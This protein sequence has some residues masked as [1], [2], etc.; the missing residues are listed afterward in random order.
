MYFLCKQ[1]TNV[2]IFSIKVVCMLIKE[3]GLEREMWLLDSDNRI[4]EAPMYNFPADEMG[5]LVEVRSAWGSNP[6]RVVDTLG[7]AESNEREKARVLGLKILLSPEM[8]VTDEWQ[9]Y[10]AEK[11]HHASFGDSTQNIYGKTE[12][13]HNTG[14]LPG[15][16]TAGM[17][18]HF[19]IW[20]TEKEK[21]RDFTKD[22]IRH[23][24]FELDNTFKDYV[25]S[26][27]RMLGEWEP[28]K[29][30]FEYRSLPC[31]TNPFDLAVK[32]QEVINKISV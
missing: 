26:N 32:G 23:M 9:K 18:V 29:H 28:K 21:F 14:L 30:G 2:Y 20:D 24:V 1:Y 10:I 17:H 15:R 8:K 13:T 12:H 7:L 6:E 16:A 27:K 3:I 25:V 22:E 11:Y 5:F 19:S 4:V 31:T